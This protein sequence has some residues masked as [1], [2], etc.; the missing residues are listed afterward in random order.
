MRYFF[1]LQKY[2][3]KMNMIYKKRYLAYKIRQMHELE[4]K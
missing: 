3:I 1:Q 2:I 4:P